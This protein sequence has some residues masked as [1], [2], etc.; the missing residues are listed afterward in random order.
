MRNIVNKLF[1][2]IEKQQ[3]EIDHLKHNH[4]SIVGLYQKLQEQYLNDI[5]SLKKDIFQS[6]VQLQS[7]Q[8]TFEND[9]VFNDMKTRVQALENTTKGLKCDIVNNDQLNSK[10]LLSLE[11]RQDSDYEEVRNQILELQ[12]FP[13]KRPS[14]YQNEEDR[15][16]IVN[17]NMDISPLM[18]GIYRDSRRLDG[19]N[20]T[21]SNIRNEYSDIADSII[22]IQDVLSSFNH[23]I[24]EI[25]RMCTGFGSSVN[26]IAGFL[27]S[28][29]VNIEK[30]VNELWNSMKEQSDALNH[31]TTHIGRLTEQLETHF[32]RITSKSLPA[33]ITCSDIQVESFDLSEEMGLKS[34][35][36]ESD[37]DKF[38]VMPSFKAFPASFKDTKI[39]KIEKKYDPK[40]N[41]FMSSVDY[42]RS[43]TSTIQSPDQFCLNE[44]AERITRLENNIDEKLSNIPNKSHSNIPTTTHFDSYIAEK[45]FQKIEKS[46]EKLNQR[47]LSIEGKMIVHSIPSSAQQFK[48]NPDQVIGNK[49]KNSGESSQRTPR[50]VISRNNIRLA[51]DLY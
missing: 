5:E 21:V 35:R 25:H 49:L 43:K 6:K 2:I 28:S 30:H 17:G 50:K 4:S 26:S 14:T 33:L 24:N 16:Q 45:M 19:L 15:P 36:F 9:L 46:L 3:M 47:I 20:E 22:A 41:I 10:L 39:P 18:R 32:S 1:V 31:T 51:S 38:Q 40:N 7:F 12:Q 42:L 34:S 44:I 48:P 13:I 29:I 23:N 27:Q 8:T 37:R 11:K